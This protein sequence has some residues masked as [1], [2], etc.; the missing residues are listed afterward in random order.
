MRPTKLQG[1]EPISRGTVFLTA[2]ETAALLRVSAITLGR[3]R[4]EGRGPLFRKLGRRVVYAQDDV[5]AW[6]KQQ[7]RSNTSGQC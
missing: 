2:G 6:A 3:W 4:I 1:P 7:T 5:L